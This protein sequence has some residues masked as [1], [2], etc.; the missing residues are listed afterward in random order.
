M[1]F[2]PRKTNY[3]LYN[4]PNVPPQ[5]LFLNK[6]SAHWCPSQSSSPPVTIPG[7][8]TTGCLTVKPSLSSLRPGGSGNGPVMASVTNCGNDAGIALY[9]NNTNHQVE[10]IQPMNQQQLSTHEN[11]LILSSFWTRFDLSFL[12][13]SSS[14]LEWE[15]VE[16]F[17]FENSEPFLRLRNDIVL[18][19][20]P[21]SKRSM[22]AMRE[23]LL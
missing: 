18:F 17:D 2:K 19:I 7:T 8:N 22:N 5:S 23:S 9:K 1:H 12:L 3:L 15:S 16:L 20:F 11:F 10:H 14:L 6:P 4:S 21:F 13:L